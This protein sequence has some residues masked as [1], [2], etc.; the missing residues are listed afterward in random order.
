MQPAA[1][2]LHEPNA[3][4]GGRQMGAAR[5]GCAS[6]RAQRV[7]GSS[8][9]GNARWGLGPVE[10]TKRQ[11]PAASSAAL[12]YFTSEPTINDPRRRTSPPFHSLL[13]TFCLLCFNRTTTGSGIWLRGFARHFRPIRKEQRREE[14]ENR[15]TALEVDCRSRCSRRWYRLSSCCAG[16]D[17]RMR[18]RC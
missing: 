17:G 3:N 12:L 16:Q 4:E 11:A 2:H 6:Q 1:A 10:G 8:R 18:I 9:G 5:A 13:R 7:S 14:R 15:E